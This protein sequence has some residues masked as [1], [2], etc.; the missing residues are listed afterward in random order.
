MPLR[1]KSNSEEPNENHERQVSELDNLIMYLT[2]VVDSI[3]VH[4]APA[5][6]PDHGQD[7]IPNGHI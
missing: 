2:E 7:G 3:E 1:R 5:P 4:L 6:R